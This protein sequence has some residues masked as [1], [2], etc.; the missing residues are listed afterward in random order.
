MWVYIY[1]TCAFS[2][3]PH[4]KEKQAD[5]YF[6]GVGLIFILFSTCLAI[7]LVT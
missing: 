6:E 7:H 2:S 3:S 5:F 1:A 4:F